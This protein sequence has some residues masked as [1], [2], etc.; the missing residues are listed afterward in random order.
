MRDVC[1]ILDMRQSDFVVRSEDKSNHPARN[2][3][4]SNHPAKCE[5]KSSRSAKSENISS[6]PT[7]TEDKLKANDIINPKKA[8]HLP[9]SATKEYTSRASEILNPAVESVEH[10]LNSDL[11]KI[12][13]TDS[14]FSVDFDNRFKTQVC[15]HHADFTNGV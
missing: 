2:E 15:P 12:D 11:P 14:C 13:E 10:I 1:T 3:D 9:N 4:K 8:I 7:K 6:C 5:D